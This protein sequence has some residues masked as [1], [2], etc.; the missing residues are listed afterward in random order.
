MV[1]PRDCAQQGKQ[2]DWTCGLLWCTVVQWVTCRARVLQHQGPGAGFRY[3][4]ACGHMR[5]QGH[6]CT[7]GSYCVQA[8]LWLSAAVVAVAVLEFGADLQC[9][10]SFHPPP[11]VHHF[12]GIIAR[13]LPVPRSVTTDHPVEV[14]QGRP[15][16]GNCMHLR[17]E[18]VN[19]SLGSE[20]HWAVLLGVRLGSMPG[21]GSKLGGRVAGV[22][23]TRMLRFNKG[24][25]GT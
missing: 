23:G 21:A 1:L 10:C 6:A 24:G 11:P 13:V 7:R 25:R 14:R 5:R 2:L 19:T 17:R 9:L 18:D 22:T 16:Q 20:A 4:P 15:P 8:I 3:G 12:L